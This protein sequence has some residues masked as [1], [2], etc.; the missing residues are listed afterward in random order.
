MKLMKKMM[1]LVIAMV[2]VLAMALPALAANDT[3]T[4]KLDT[5]NP[6]AADANVKSEL[7]T[8]YKIFDVEK[9]EGAT[10]NNDDS[11]LS[12]NTEPN[13]AVTGYSYTI[14]TSSKWYSVV[15]NKLG[16]YIT[17]Q[18]IAGDTT[19]KTVTLKEGVQNVSN[20]A[21]EIAAILKN[22][23]P[24]NLVKDTD[25]WEM[26][27]DSA[28]LPEAIEV[29]AGYYLMSSS[30]GSN[31]IAATT[32]INLTEKNTYPSI[33][34]KQNDATPGNYKDDVVSVGIGDTIYYELVV[35]VPA[36][37]DKL[38]T[39]TDK[40]SAGLTFSASDSDI[41]LKS[42]ENK[43][44]FGT[45]LAKGTY[46]AASGSTSEDISGGEWDASETS[47]SGFVVKIKPTEATKGKYVQITFQA[48]VNEN[49]IISDTTKQNDV[50]LTYSN[51][52]Q[53][54][55]V[56]YETNATGA[57][58]FDG[59]LAEKKDGNTL[60]YKEGKSESDGDYLLAGAEFK[61]QKK[62]GA[63]GTWTDVTVSVDSNG[64]YYPDASGTAVI[65]SSSTEGVKGQ[66]IIRG[67]DAHTRSDEG[68]DTITYQ[69]VE[70]KAPASGYN[71]MTEPAPLTLTK[72]D[73]AKVSINSGSDTDTTYL[74][75]A[76]VVKIENNKG[77]LLPSTGGIGTTIFYVI[78]SILVIGAGVLLVVKKRMSA[79]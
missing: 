50:T 40:M 41:T 78:G 11:T 65:T 23:I 66:I 46:S 76:S 38:I 25:Y 55:R 53:S 79:E 1:A 14:S 71:M 34:K 58:K 49:A 22:N 19:K 62:V 42:G 18:D 45:T 51:Y 27:K 44:S 63:S 24:S 77:S 16:D 5:S 26:Q 12:G 43:T 72:D 75:A 67:L 20:T 13:P 6:D 73:K 59:D 7:Y 37:A 28:N 31:M 15:S 68:S 9:A 4:I 74:T 33:D 29:P 57:V 35:Y 56:N 2:M 10:G 17:L 3:I 30:L 61:L 64:H 39:V 21:K 52:S 69:L 70:T 60:G 8:A 54:D 47:A 32:N 36:S 48:T